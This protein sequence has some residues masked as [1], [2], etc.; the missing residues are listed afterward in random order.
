LVANEAEAFVKTRSIIANLGQSEGRYPRRLVRQRAPR[1]PRYDPRELYG[2]VGSD[3]R[4]SFP[5]IEVIARLVDDSC[6][7][8]FKRDWGVTVRCGFSHVAG[9]L[10]GIVAN[11]GILFSES[12]QKVAH[13]IELCNQREI[14]LLFLQNIVGFMVGKEYEHGGIAK[15]GAKMV[16]AVATARVPKITLLVGASYG[17]GNYAMCGRAYDPHL[18][19]AWPNAKISVM[20]GAQAAR[21]LTE[22]RGQR[23]AVEQERFEGAILEKY[24]RE[25]AALYASARMW[26]DGII[27]PMH[28]R[29]VLELALSLVR[30]PIVESGAQTFFRM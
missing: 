30:F 9:Y 21:V 12:A 26:D 14:P 28:T 16:A 20:G 25:G 11:D 19:F 23:S 3:L 7:D 18:L 15:H 5:I 1:E 17:A 22:V 27:D 4:K 8:E 13:F 6:F 10:V 2:I 29:R 24:E